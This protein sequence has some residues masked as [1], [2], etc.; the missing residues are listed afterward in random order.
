MRTEVEHHL[1]LT[2]AEN[3]RICERTETRNDLNWS[4]TCVV[5][6]AVFECPSV[7]IPDPA[8]DGAVNKRSPEKDEDHRW[9]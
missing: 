8:C 4:A 3:H 5:E 9:D 7:D 1:L 2:F 6:H